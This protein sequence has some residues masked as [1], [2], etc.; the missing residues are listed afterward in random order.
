MTV[1][2]TNSGRATMELIQFKM[3]RAVYEIG[4]CPPMENMLFGTVALIGLWVWKTGRV[5]KEVFS[6]TL[7]MTSVP[8][9]R[10]L[11][12]NTLYQPLINLLMLIVV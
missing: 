6:L 12:G 11:T 3:V 8:I 4:T 5:Q 9:S 2:R 7:M 1:G 10:R